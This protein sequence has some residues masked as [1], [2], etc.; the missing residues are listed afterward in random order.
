MIKQKRQKKCK[1]KKRLRQDQSETKGI[2]VG[3]V[4]NSYNKIM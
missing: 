2:I 1:K 3:I 4:N